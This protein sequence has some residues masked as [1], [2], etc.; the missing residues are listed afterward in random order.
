MTKIEMIIAAATTLLT[1]VGAFLTALLKSMKG[2]KNIKRT[3]KFVESIS[4]LF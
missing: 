1:T 2:K 3:L 4:D